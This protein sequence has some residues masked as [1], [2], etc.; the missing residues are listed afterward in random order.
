MNEF[1]PYIGLI[2]GVIITGLLV[3]IVQN[4]PAL[5][6][7]VKG[8][9]TTGVAEID[10]VLKSAIDFATKFVENLDQRGLLDEA[11]LQLKDK[12]RVKLDLATDEAVKYIENVL[13]QSGI[14]VDIDEELIKKTIQQYVWDNPDL[15]PSKG[16]ETKNIIG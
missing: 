4:I 9:K 8:I 7:A 15:F 2:I 13:R 12:G 11:L 16:T 6:K 5:V 1:L 10:Q 14:E 3:L